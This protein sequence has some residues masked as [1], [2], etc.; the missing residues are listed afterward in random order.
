MAA[1]AKQAR[2]AARN[3]YRRA[4]DN[5]ERLDLERA[6]EVE[7]RGAQIGRFDDAAQ[8]RLLGRVVAQPVEALDAGRA[9]S[10]NRP[11]TDRVDADLLL[12]AEVPGQIA[13]ALL[14]GRFADAHHVVAGHDLL[15]ADIS[16]R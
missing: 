6:Q 8:A 12:A 3:F 11:G 5:A 13:D 16:N 9:E 14:Q 15:A 7:G 2:A 4:L 10:A 1:A